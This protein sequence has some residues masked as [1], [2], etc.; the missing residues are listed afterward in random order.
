MSGAL[1]DR[2]GEAR[3]RLEGFLADGDLPEPAGLP[4]YVAPLPRLLEDIGLRLAWPIV[5]VNL[6]GTAFGFW[7]YRF[8]FERTATVL[9]PFVPDSPAATLFI[10]LSLAAWKLGRTNEYLNAL[11]FFGCIKLGAWTPF[12]L[13]AYPAANL[14]TTPLWLYLFLV[15]SHLAM[16]VQAFLIHRY[17]GFPVAAVG[18]AAAWYSLDYAIDYLVPVASGFTHTTL[19]P[20]LTADGIDHS[21]FAH[22]LAA[23]GA[24]VLLVVP[25]FLALATRVEMLQRQRET[26]ADTTPDPDSKR[27]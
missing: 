11:A 23:A 15:T 7:Y 5:A 20:E 1:G 12:V 27:T 21:V 22:D 6:A 17:A 10:A 19:V 4:R 2:V 24:L 8:Q 3:D 14:A 9:L 18:A 16:V 13:L 26:G 25:L